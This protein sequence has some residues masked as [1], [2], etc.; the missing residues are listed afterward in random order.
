MRKE[1]EYAIPAGR[2]GTTE[3]VA[4]IILQTAESPAYMTGQVIGIDG[5]F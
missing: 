5:G 1:L 3:E 4:R 2:F